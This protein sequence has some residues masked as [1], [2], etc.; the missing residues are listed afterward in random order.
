MYCKGGYLQNDLLR[1]HYWQI[2]G[3]CTKFA[4]VTKISQV[5]VFHLTTA[6]TG[7]LQRCIQ[8]LVNIHNVAILWKYLT[9][10]N[11]YLSSQK[12]LRRRCLS[13]LKI[14]FWLRVWN[15]EFTLI[16]SLQINSRKCSAG[17]SVWHLFWK[18]KR[19]WR[20]SKQNECLYG[21]S[22][23]KGFLR[24]VLSE[25]LQDSQEKICAEISF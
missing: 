18:S 3:Q 8:K 16:P 4:R 1:S 25:I 7:C 24:K 17:K 2:Y 20:D 10:L 22:S 19:S 12:K 13:G 9:A 11:C 23:T 15:I 5:L 21:S 6:V 14:S